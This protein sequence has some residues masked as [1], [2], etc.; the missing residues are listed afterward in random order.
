MTLCDQINN[1]KAFDSGAGSLDNSPK[2]LASPVSDTILLKRQIQQIESQIDESQRTSEIEKR[3]IIA[4]LRSEEETLAN[5]LKL[6]EKIT[7]QL[8]DI[9]LDYQVSVKVMKE[10]NSDFDQ[11]F[12]LS[13]MQ[14]LDSEKSKKESRLIATKKTHEEEIYKR[15]VKVSALRRQLC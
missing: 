4:E 10:E 9:E 6:V 3:L 11:D 7:I 8:R 2:D 13:K 14:E 5:D 1:G 15:R 12:I